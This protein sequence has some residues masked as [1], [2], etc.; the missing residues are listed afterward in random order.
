MQHRRARLL[1]MLWRVRATL[2]DRPGELANLAQRCG[3]AG[4]NILALQ[5]FPGID[6]V[7]DEMVLRA[8]DGWQEADLQRLLGAG[9]VVQPCT[10]EALADHYENLCAFDNRLVLA[11]EH[12][13]DLPAWQEGAILSALDAIVRLHE[14]VVKI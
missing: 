7:T 6:D 5:I 9:A 13:S 8:P 3:E 12:A 11:G 2:P 14:R 1:R 4:V 10:E